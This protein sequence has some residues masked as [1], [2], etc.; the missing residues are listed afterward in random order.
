[1]SSQI[2]PN[3]GRKRCVC[4]QGKRQTNHVLDPR[5]AEVKKAKEEAKTLAETSTAKP[6]AIM[7]QVQKNMSAE[8]LV[9]MPSIAT[10]SRQIQLA[11]KCET[12][13]KVPKTLDEL[14]LPEDANTGENVVVY[15]SGKSDKNRLI[16]LSTKN[17]M[18]FL[19]TCPYIHVDGTF[20]SCPTL[21]YQIYTIHGE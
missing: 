14:D 13:P 16:I 5:D 10:V 15:D 19:A 3:F 8:A 6:Q 2:E 20:D 7:A 11:R 1:M 18:D 17:N 21:F 9:Q 4:L 12:Q